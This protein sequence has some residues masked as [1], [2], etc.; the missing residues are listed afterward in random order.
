MLLLVM[1]PS[2]LTVV[3]F[4]GDRKSLLSPWWS[5]SFFIRG[6]HVD[7]IIGRRRKPF[8]IPKIIIATHVLK[9]L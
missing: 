5:D 3:S 7:R 2:N 4:D 9:K 6:P 1:L 8:E